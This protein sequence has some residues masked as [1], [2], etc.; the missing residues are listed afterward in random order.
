MPHRGCL[1][2][3]AIGCGLG[4]SVSGSVGGSLSQ[5]LQVGGVLNTATNDSLGQNR[6]V[7]A[8]TYGIS[9]MASDWFTQVILTD[10]ER[11]LSEESG[12][13]PRNRLVF[14]TRSILKLPSGIY[15]SVE[16]TP[17]VDF[18]RDGKAGISLGGR[19]GIMLGESQIMGFFAQVD[20]PFDSYSRSVEARFSASLGFEIVAPRGEAAEE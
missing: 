20:R 6:W 15:S 19:L 1:Q 9:W 16:T 10:W 18:K 8:P 2:G 7:I 17:F 3:V 14:R 11:S 5:L 12:A 13:I 4:K